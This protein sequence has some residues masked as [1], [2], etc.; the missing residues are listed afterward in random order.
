MGVGMKLHRGCGDDIAQ[1][2]RGTSADEFHHLPG[3]PQGSGSLMG[4]L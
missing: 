4:V 3:Q 2:E 1:I